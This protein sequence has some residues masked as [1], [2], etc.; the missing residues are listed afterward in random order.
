MDLLIV[1]LRMMLSMLQKIKTKTNRK[2]EKTPVLETE[3]T[4]LAWL[5]ESGGVSQADYNRIGNEVAE[6]IL[7]EIPDADRQAAPAKEFLSNAKF[8]LAMVENGTIS[9]R[10][11]EPVTEESFTASFESNNPGF[12]LESLGGFNQEGIARALAVDDK[13]QK[14]ER[15]N[16]L[17]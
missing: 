11:G 6:T 3:N 4:Y 13:R 10:T 12:I 14:S 16:S 2:G 15:L 17:V 5:L 7:F 9:P 1:I 8:V